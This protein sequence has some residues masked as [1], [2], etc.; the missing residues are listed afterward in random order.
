MLIGLILLIV[1]DV[2]LVVAAYYLQ[3][4]ANAVHGMSFTVSVLLALSALAVHLLASW[5][6]AMELD[7]S[8]HGGRLMYLMF[9]VLFGAP[10]AYTFGTVVIEAG[11][12]SG[13]DRLMGLGMSRRPTSDFSRARALAERDD[14]DGAINQY[15]VYFSELPT[16]AAPLF[17]I[18]NLLSREHRWNEAADTLRS[19]IGRFQQQEDVW[20]KASFRL[21][22]VLLQELNE[23]EQAIFILREIARRLPKSDVGVRA[24]QW[25][26]D[27]EVPA[28][29]DSDES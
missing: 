28:I 12:N 18:A 4:R 7:L 27:L 21:A 29:I 24:R 23:R 19:I 14:I 5:P 13:T 20:A 6:L 15:R 3:Q 8:T 26:M 17:E 16:D 2:A 25:L 10:A 11:A 1:V 9:V 22:T